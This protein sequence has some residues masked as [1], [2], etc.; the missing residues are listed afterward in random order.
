MILQ[1]REDLE[2]DLE[3]EKS[4]EQRA[5]EAKLAEEVLRVRELK[6]QQRAAEQHVRVCVDN[7][8]DS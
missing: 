2:T 6:Q 1:R 3:D 8:A 4:P 5:Y 7:L